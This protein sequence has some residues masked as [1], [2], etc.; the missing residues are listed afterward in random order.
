MVEPAIIAAAITVIGTIVIAV[1][2]W[3]YRKRNKRIVRVETDTTEIEEDISALQSRVDTLWRWAF[4][5][6]DDATDKGIS[7]EIEEGFDNIEKDIGEVRKRQ[8][9]YHDVE[10]DRLEQLVNELHDDEDVDVERE[11]VFED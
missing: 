8:E 2:G 5:R 1:V 6:E 3:L 10:M 11:D 9:T 7:K 4:G